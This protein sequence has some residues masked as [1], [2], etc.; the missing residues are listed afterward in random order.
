MRAVA[1]ELSTIGE[2]VRA[3]SME[4]KENFPEIP[5]GKIQGIRNVLIHEYFRLDEKIIWQTVQIDIPN[6]K[7]LLENI[8]LNSRLFL[9][10]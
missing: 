9:R 4:I 2:A 1:F 7:R 8:N 3:L 5:W 10:K 6:L